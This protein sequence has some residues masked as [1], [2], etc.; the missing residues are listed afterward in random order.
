MEIRAIPKF[1]FECAA[2]F[3]VNQTV[4]VSQGVS[5]PMKC[6]ALDW[7]TSEKPQLSCG[8]VSRLKQPWLLT[9][10]T[11]IVLELLPAYQHSGYNMNHKRLSPR[12]IIETINLW[13]ITI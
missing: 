9:R 10:L 2:H 12:E 3:F 5:L 11:Y 7:L 1:R 4:H 6:T 13:S 8:P